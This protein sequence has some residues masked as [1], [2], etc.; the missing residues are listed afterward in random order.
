[1]DPARGRP[2]AAE[3]WRLHP[4]CAISAVQ[5][6]RNGLHAGVTAGASGEDRN[7]HM[8]GAAAA[9]G[10]SH[11]ARGLM[12]CGPLLPPA[13]LRTERIGVPAEDC[14]AVAVAARRHALCE[15]RPTFACCLPRRGMLG[16]AARWADT[17][18]AAL[19]QQP[20]RALQQGTRLPQVCWRSNAASS[21]SEGGAGP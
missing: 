19:P 13:A 3:C 1:M 11:G 5:R 15:R 4:C 12:A 7:L 17:S 18:D 10:A 20:P 21:G 2:S 16:M 9:A 8:A 6:T 14:G